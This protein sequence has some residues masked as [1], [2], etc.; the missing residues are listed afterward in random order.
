MVKS[1]P[2]AAAIGNFDGVH[3]G[4]QALL[5]ALREFA[6]EQDAKPAAVVFDPHPRRYF[7]PDDPPF[8]L[9]TPTERARLLRAEGMREVMPLAFD[10]ALAG[11]SPADFVQQTLKGSLGLSAVMVGADFRFGSGR[12]GDATM[13]A[14]LCQQNGLAFR[15]FVPVSVDGE[16]VMPGADASGTSGRPLEKV[17]ST[18]VRD[19]IARGDMLAAAD[20]L[21]R[22]W[23]VIGNVEKG[24]QLGRTLNFPT[25]NLKLGELIAPRIGVYAVIAEL[26]G[27]RFDGVANYGRRP[28]VGGS[29]PLL[30]VHLFNFNGDLYG[31]TMSV[32][33]VDFIR[34]EQKF[35]G[36]DALKAQIARDSETARQR[37][38]ALSSARSR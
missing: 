8:L 7:R 10:A 35:D 17:G 16:A 18:G 12:A 38:S 22:P 32:E 27:E 9:T 6:E 1:S 15:A 19:A 5:L 34:P 11:L 14:D 21:G 29:D 20:M 37:L 33:F 4:H 2:V 23:R 13:L 31:R 3:R 25:A 26:D 36:L 30:E 24:Q 28:T